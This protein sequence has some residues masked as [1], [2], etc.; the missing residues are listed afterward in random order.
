MNCRDC[1]AKISDLSADALASSD[2]VLMREHL[3]DCRA[4]KEEM[5]ILER[6][7]FSVSSATQTLPSALASEQMWHRCSEHI[8]QKVE[9]ERA[10]A[11]QPIAAQREYS[12]QG[13][14]SWFSRQPRWSWAALSGALA[15]L[16]SA[17][18]FNSP[19]SSSSPDFPVA[20]NS[21][22]QLVALQRPSGPAS[23]LINHHSAMSVDPF[24]DYVGTTL[25][26]Y[27]ATSN[28]SSPRP[29]R[30]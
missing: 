11:K 4:C 22:G 12:L 30:R 19:E 7:L 23:V 10:G 16:A 1:Q 9:A 18:L 6:T 3:E 17:W 26:S 14:A 24:T 5:A 28:A 8:F 15:I 2:A 29:A 27:S 21:P 25:V 20:D 13:N